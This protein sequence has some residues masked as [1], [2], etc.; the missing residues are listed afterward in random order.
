MAQLV[1]EV[2][3]MTGPGVKQEVSKTFGKMADMPKEVKL[4][5]PGRPRNPRNCP[6]LKG[7]K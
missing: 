2:Q 3:E 7:L 5:R 4:K 6:Y 1:I